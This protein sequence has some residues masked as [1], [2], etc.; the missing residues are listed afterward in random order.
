MSSNPRL[1]DIYLYVDLV[2][3]G[4]FMYEY[5]TYRYSSHEMYIYLRNMNGLWFY[6]LSN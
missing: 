3:D 6:I 2:F 1:Q 5:F 4:G